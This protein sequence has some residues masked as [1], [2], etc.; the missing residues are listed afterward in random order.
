M[1]MMSLEVDLSVKWLGYVFVVWWGSFIWFYLVGFCIFLL[2]Y[3]IV[4]VW[5]VVVFM[6]CFL[7]DISNFVKIVVYR[8]SI[9]ICFF[10]DGRVGMRYY[11][12]FVV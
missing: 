3:L 9:C 5:G 4:N 10:L 2:L 1:I 7:C 11:R 8:Y 6:V 12:F